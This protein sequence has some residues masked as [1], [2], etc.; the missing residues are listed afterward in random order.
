MSIGG[1]PMTSSFKV[2]LLDVM[3]TLRYCCECLLVSHVLCHSHG[4]LSLVMV[5][6]YMCMCCLS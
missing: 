5:K 1:R 3:V 2:I 4:L 6:Q